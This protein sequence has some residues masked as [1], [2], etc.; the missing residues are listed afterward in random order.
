MVTSTKAALEQ[1]VESDHESLS[2]DFGDSETTSDH[3][4]CMKVAAG[5]ALAGISYDFGQLTIMKA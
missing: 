4:G 2:G 1:D 3:S 5:A